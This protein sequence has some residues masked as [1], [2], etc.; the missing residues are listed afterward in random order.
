MMYKETPFT[1][2]IEVG[3]DHLEAPEDFRYTG[4]E[5]LDSVAKD[6]GFKDWEEMR[7][8]FK[9]LYGLPWKGTVKYYVVF[10]ENV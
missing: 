1:E 9:N 5:E 6:Y 8:H 4:P 7:D 3:E 2:I 10:E